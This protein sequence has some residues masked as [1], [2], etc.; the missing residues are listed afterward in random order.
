MGETGLAQ[1]GSPPLE[2]ILEDL[3]LS[4]RLVLHSVAS[5]TGTRDEH[6]LWLDDTFPTVIA[7]GSWGPESASL[8]R[9]AK[10]ERSVM[11][12]LSDDEQPVR[13]PVRCPFCHSK[14]VGTLAKEITPA[15]Y[16]RCHACGGGWNPAQLAREKPSR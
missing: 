16:W 4:C 3:S 2:I 13:R 1:D 10:L 14:A 11:N 12:R 9:V 5:R 7:R 8:M 15:T 6:Q